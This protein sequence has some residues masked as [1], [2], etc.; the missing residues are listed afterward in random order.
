M[1]V[2]NYDG[3]IDFTIDLE[4]ISQ[5]FVGCVIGQST[6]KQFGPYGILVT[7]W[8]S[9]IEILSVDFFLLFY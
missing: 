5:R 8:K 1:P 3:F 4:V 7:G 9:D 2:G 6:H